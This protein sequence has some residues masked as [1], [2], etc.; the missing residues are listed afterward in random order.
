MTA[1]YLES[2]SRSYAPKPV[3]PADKGIPLGVFLAAWIISIPLAFV[4]HH[5]KELPSS[6]E[7]LEN[8][9]IAVGIRGDHF[10]PMFEVNGVRMRG[11][12]D[13]G[14]TYLSLTRSDAAKAGIDLDRLRYNGTV[15]T[16]NG[17]RSI[18]TTKVDS[19]TLGGITFRNVKV[20]IGKNGKA[21]SNLIGMEVLRRF[22]RI[23]IEGREMRLEG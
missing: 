17:R 3:K 4:I 18:A 21:S 1:P 22:K 23:T 7:T 9:A 13:T 8:G 6:V 5:I 16:P 20:S 12:I 2:I 15:K 14:A 11:V 10:E 19:V